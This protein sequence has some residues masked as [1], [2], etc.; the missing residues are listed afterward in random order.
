MNSEPCV[1]MLDNFLVPELQNFPGYNK[2]TLFQRD[3]ATSHMSNTSL[4]RVREIFS[5]KF[6]SRR[7]D[8][9]WPP[10][11][12]DLTPMDFFLWG[13]LDSKVYTNKPTSLV[14][15]KENICHEMAT[16]TEFTS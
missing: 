15:L 10:C 2:R 11:S 13:Y 7:G 9:N 12:P 3:E 1:E 16:I 14:L 4:P 6:I 5:G 8:K